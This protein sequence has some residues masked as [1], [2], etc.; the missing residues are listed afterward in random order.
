MN[1]DLWMHADLGGVR[2]LESSTSKSQTALNQRQDPFRRGGL[3]MRLLERS[4]SQPL[5]SLGCQMRP[6]SIRKAQ[7]ESPSVE[8]VGDGHRDLIV[9]RF[10]KQ[11]EGTILEGT[12]PVGKFSRFFLLPQIFDGKL[13][14]PIHEYPHFACPSNLYLLRLF[15]VGSDR[16]L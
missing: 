9:A 12:S 11:W 8:V 3:I 7:H 5:C 15:P 14:F 13:Q 2:T 4:G 16:G 10:Q 1:T 6:F